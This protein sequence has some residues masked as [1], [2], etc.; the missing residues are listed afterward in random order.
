ME[1]ILRQSCRTEG[2]L[3][4][5]EVAFPVRIPIRVI[6]PKFM[7]GKP[8][9]SGVVEAIGQMVACGLATGGVAGPAAGGHPLLAV[10]GSIGVD[11]HQ[12]D[13]AFAQLPAPG[14]HA[15]GAGHE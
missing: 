5:V 8:E 1:E 9:H 7:P 15:L 3:Q 13:I 2:I 10:A 12:A 4:D 6:L 11:R 14:V